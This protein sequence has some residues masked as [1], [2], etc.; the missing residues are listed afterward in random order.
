[1]DIFCSFTIV[2]KQP[3]KTGHASSVRWTYHIFYKT[4]YLPSP[5]ISHRQMEH[6]Q[7]FLHVVFELCPQLVPPQLDHIYIYIYI[8]IQIIT[9][10]IIILIIIM[11]TIHT[12]LIF[13]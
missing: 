13:K 2:L 3:H 8:N 5:A 9:T 11:N 1:M 7:L 4:I 10:I 12:W 6:L